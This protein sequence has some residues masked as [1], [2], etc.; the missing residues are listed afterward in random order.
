MTSFDA[1]L[2]GIPSHQDWGA[3]RN[4]FVSYVTNEVAAWVPSTSPHFGQQLAFATG[5]LEEGYGLTRFFELYNDSTR[6][7][8]LRI[9]DIGAGNGG[10]ALGLANDVRYRVTTLDLVPNRD[11]RAL[12]KAT[13]LPIMP[14]VGDGK[15]LPFK[16]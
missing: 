1:D 14:T 13:T 7:R 5:R 4:Q 8:P 12:Q 10:V 16:S 15:K 9:L 6:D 11:L 3:L 2:K